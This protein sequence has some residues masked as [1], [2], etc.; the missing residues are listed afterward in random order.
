MKSQADLSALLS[1]LDRQGYRAYKQ[2]KGEYQFPDFR[3]I[4]D[5]VQGDPFAAPSQCT[6]LVPQAIAKFPPALYRNLS[7]EIALRD[8]LTRRF[9]Q[10]AKDFSGLRGTGKSGLIQGVE[11]APEVI[12]RTAVFIDD[13]DVEVRFWVGLPAKGRSILG[14]QAA[15]MLCDDL[16]QIVR[17]SLFFDSFNAAAV[18][19]YVETIED[20][21]WIRGQLSQRGLVAFIGDGAILA[22]CSGVDAHPLTEKVIPFQSPPELRI[23]FDCP[24]HGT[25][26]G[27]GVKQGIT[28]IVGGGYHG[29]STLLKAIDRGVYNHRPGDGREWVITDARAVKIRAEDGRSIVGVDIS[30]FISRL[31]QDQ[32]TQAFSSHNASGSTSQATNIIEA[33]EVGAKVLL[34]DEDTSATNFMVRD[35]RMQQLIQKDREPITP[36]VDKVRQLYED[37]GVSTIL[38]MGGSGDYFDVADT[39]IALDNFQPQDVTAAAQKIAAAYKTERLSEGGSQFGPITPRIPV[40]ASIDASRGNRSITLKVRDTHHLGFGTEEIDLSGVEQLV[41]TTQLRAIALG[42]LYGRDRYGQDKLPLKTLLDR[43]MADLEA[44]GLDI[45]SDYPQADLGSFRRFELGAA[46]NRLRSLQ[47]LPRET[48]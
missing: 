26:T 18:Q 46:L 20:A 15:E 22:R 32:S 37:H 24:N 27:M 35:R 9:S 8:Y 41:E 13:Q 16:P 29:K 6:V 2:L 14:R 1:A 43:V 38:V 3:L 17:K 33:L 11:A 7:R 28:L 31:P 40:A 42:L 12:E 39:V 19:A 10:V 5:Y 48:T 44:A 25:M 36:F 4:I 30:P 23:S 34:L 21:D 45:L 47:I